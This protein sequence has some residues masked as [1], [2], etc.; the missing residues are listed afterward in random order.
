MAVPL[1]YVRAVLVLAKPPYLRWAVAGA[2]IVGALVWDL[3]SRATQP[4]AVAALPIA[5][6]ATIDPDTIRWVDVPVGVFDPIDPSG[7]TAVVAIGEGEPI[8]PSVVTVGAVVPDGWW[9]VGADIPFAAVRGSRVR[10]V[11]ADGSGITGVVVE[12]S[13]EDSFGIPSP[14]L[15]AV[16]GETAD[17][18]A[19]AAA[20]GELVILFEP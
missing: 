17:I 12:P 4:V 13:V 16:P 9:T 7:T 6:G 5:R 8:T 11:L 15:L 20:A 19:L 1:G 14:G 10:V 2:L 3:S 18:V